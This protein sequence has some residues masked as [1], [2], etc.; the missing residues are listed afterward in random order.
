MGGDL[1]G[2]SSP[3]RATL[4]PAT[5]IV[6]AP[7][8]TISV[9]TANW[10]DRETCIRLLAAQL[11]EHNLPTDPTGTGNGVDLALAPHSP[12]WLLLAE[13]DNVPVGILLANQ[14]VSVEQRGYT[15][16]VE[17]LYVVPEA[18]RRRVATA[19]LDYL[20]TEGRRRGVIAVELEVLPTQTAAFALYRARGFRDVHRQRMTWDLTWP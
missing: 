15:L 2:T 10:G 17:E 20:M 12:A 19:F 6:Y 8:V 14:I 1:Q 4:Q 16:W 18:R 3:G 5:L 9:R 11:L 7:F 13:L